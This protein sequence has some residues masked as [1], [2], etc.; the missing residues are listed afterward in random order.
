M[1]QRFGQ[2]LE[3]AWNGELSS[4]VLFSII[5]YR[6]PESL[7]LILPLSFFLGVFVSYGRLYVDSEMVV[8]SSCGFSKRRLLTYSLVPAS[9]VAAT[10]A[11][12]ALV[13][14]PWGLQQVQTIQIEQKDRSALDILAANRF[15]VFSKDEAVIYFQSFNENRDRINDVFIAEMA[16]G[17]LI[18]GHQRLSMMTAAQGED[19][20]HPQNGERYLMLYNGYLYMGQPGDPDYQVQKFERYG[21]HLEPKS[22]ERYTRLK[23]E[24]LPTK[25]LLGNDHPRY[26]SELHW[27]IS[28]PIMVFIVTLIAVPLSHTN[29]RQGRFLKMIPAFFLFMLYLALLV[30]GKGWLEEEKTP[31]VLGLWWIHGIF[32][33]LALALIF[34]NNGQPLGNLFAVPRPV[35]RVGNGNHA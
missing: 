15:Q 14:S 5:A 34:W 20:R 28:L 33:A 13:V 4:D 32:L 18:D 21:I 23:V 2:Y 6:V 19:W 10:V 1:G 16:G 31:A 3:Q 7:T 9:V 17:S 29:P 12:L 11:V 30:I 27:R 22:P 24:N 26:T 35:R 8:L 25:D